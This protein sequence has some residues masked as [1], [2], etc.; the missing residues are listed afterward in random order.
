MTDTLAPP[1]AAE[2]AGETSALADTRYRVGDALRE[3]RAWLSARADGA[4]S[5]FLAA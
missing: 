2:A 1:D 3:A 5:R 4:V